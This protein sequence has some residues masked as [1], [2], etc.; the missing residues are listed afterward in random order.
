[1]AVIRTFFACISRMIVACVV[2]CLFINTSF[3]ACTS[4]Q[5][6]VNGNGTNCQTA[7]FTVTTTSTTTS[8]VFTMAAK[9]TFYV[10]C[11][12]N[13][14]LSQDTSSYGTISGKTVTRT[15]TNETT[16]TCTWGTAGA[17]TINFGG[18]ATA[19]N[20]SSATISFYKSSGGTQANVASIAG[21]LGLLFPAVGTRVPVFMQ[22]FHGT[23]ITSIPSGLFSSIDTSS[24]TSTLFMFSG[25]FY[26][27]SI[28]SIPSGLFSSIDTSS[29]TSTS[30]MFD[31]TFYNC[32]N[33]T[34]IPSGLFS[35]IDTSSATSTS[36]MFFMTFYYTKITSIPDGLF[37]GIDTSSATDT[38]WMFGSTFYG[39]RITSIPTGLFSGIDTSSSTKTNSMFNSTFFNTK[40]TSIPAGLFSG[41]DTSSATDTSYM[42]ES[43]FYN[44]Q[45]TSIPAG[46]FSGIDTSSSTNTNRMFYRTFYNT[47]ITSIPAGLFSTINTSSATNTNQMFAST[48]Y[49][50]S[51]LTGYIPPTAFPSTIVP[52]SS[53]S[54]DMWNQT[55]YN[56][57][58]ATACPTGTTQYTT[59]FES[60]W[61][62]SNGNTDTNGTNRVSCEPCSGSLP[63]NASW[64]A[65]T[66][67][68]ACDGGY[69]SANGTSCT[70]VE[71][72]Y[73]S[74]AGSNTRSA[75]TNGLANSTYTGSGG[76]TNS[77]PW[78]CNSGYTESNGTCMYNC[79]VGTYRP[80]LDPQVIPTNSSSN[81]SNMT[82]N[83]TASYGTL[84]G[85]A[86]CNDTSGSSANGVDF[87]TGT[88][89][90]NCW[91][92]MTEPATSAWINSLTFYFA[93]E[94]CAQSCANDCRHRISDYGE[95]REDMFSTVTCQSC[96]NKPSN[97]TY[98][99]SGGATDSCPW[100]CDS[101]YI[102]TGTACETAKF[103]VTTTSDTTSLSWTMTATGTFYVDCGDNGTLS[104]DTSSYGTISGTTITRT[105]TGETTYTCAWALAGAHTVRFG[106]LATAEYSGS[107]VGAA[108]SFYKSSGGT[109]ENVAAID[110]SLGAMF[111]FGAYTRIPKFYRTFSG[112]QITS[113][114]A[115]LFFN[116]MDTSPARF[117]THMFSRTFENCTSLQSIPDGLFNGV[118][119]SSATNTSSMFNHTFYNT[120]IT[121]IPAG[122]FSE[123]D[124]SSATNTQEMFSYTFY[125]T[126]ITSIPA[127]LFS[128]IDTSSAT[129]TNSM[130]FYTFGNT[131][132]TSIPAGLFSKIDT[133]AATN[134]SSMFF[135]T[136]YNTPITS[137]PTGL[138]SAINTSSATNTSSMFHRT[139]Y[140][141]TSLTGYIPPT[142]FPNTIVP[143]SSSSGS[144]WYQTF[145]NTQLAT[146]C[147]AG[148]GEYNTG[149]QNDWG[150]SNGNTT[151][152]GTHRVSCE[153]C[154]TLPA[155]ATWIT[156]T[157]NWTCDGGYYSADGTSC[158]AVE[159]GYYSPAGDNT[160]TACTSGP[161]NSSYTGSGGATNSCPW[162]CDGGYYSANGTSCTAVETGYYSPA[163][164]N[165]RSACTNGL[166]NSTYTGSGGATDSC[167]Y[168]C[169]NGY[170]EQSAPDL[171]ATIG[172][173]AGTNSSWNAA[174][175][176]WSA[177]YSAGTVTGKMQCSS[178]SGTNNNSN[179]TNPTISAS[180][181]DSTGQYCY[182]QIDGWTPSGGS[183]Q[184]LSSP[185]VFLEDRSNAE[186][187]SDTGGGGCA[188]RC[189]F[190]MR[191]TGASYT[192]Y[193]SAL[194]G[195][196]PAGSACAACTG[197]PAHASW[198]GNGANC[199]WVCDGGYY[200]SGNTC[201]DA[202]A[203]YYSPA[204]DN[205][206]YSCTNTKPANSSYSGSASSNACPYA[207]DGGYYMSSN[208]CVDVDTG[209]YSPAGDNTRTA[210][211]NGP[212]NS[213][214]TGSA[215]SNS[216]PWECNAGAYLNDNTCTLCAAGTY[217]AAA[218]NATTCTAAD[219]GYYVNAT[220]QTA[221]T[222]CPAG[223]RTGSDGGRDEITDCYV[224]QTA[225]CT[226]NEC[227][228]P[229]TTGCADV[230]CAESC[231]CT[232]ATYKQHVNS[233][234]DGNGSTDGTTAEN[235]TKAVA[236]LTAK[237]NYYVNGTT[238]CPACSNKPENSTY[239]AAGTNSSCPWACDGGYYSANGTSCTAVETGYYSPADDNERHACTNAPVNSTYTGSG[240]ATDSCPWA[241]DGGY[242]S[243]NG[244]S[245]TAVETGYYSPAG[246]N[247]R[248]ACTNTKPEHSSYTDS[249]G[250]TNSCPWECDSGYD[251]QDN[252]CR[253]TECTGA[254]YYDATNNICVACPIGYDANTDSGKTSA[255]QCQKTCAAGTYMRS[256][257]VVGYTRL[258]YIQT[259]GSQWINTGISSNGI[260]M[261]T[262][263]QLELTTNQTS[264]QAAIGRTVGGGYEV[265]FA[266]GGGKIGT[267][268]VSGQ[269]ADINM[270][271]GPGV[272]YTIQSEMTSSSIYTNINGATASYS[273]S[274]DTWS[275]SDGQM[276]LFRHAGNYNLSAKV[277]YVKMWQNG[278]LV[279]NYV[280]ARRDS[281]N[282]V[283]MYDLVNGTFYASN[284]SAAFISGNPVSLI[285]D[286]CE[287]VGV[288]YAAPASTINYG[289]YGTRIT[290]A[291]GTYSDVE[292]GASCK[293]CIGATYSDTT[294]ASS[295]Q[296]CPATYDY[297]TESGK[298]SI[299]QCQTHCNAGTYLDVA[300]IN[301][302][303]K[304]SYIESTGSQYIN[305][306]ISSNGMGIKA[307]V[308]FELTTNSTA[309]Q[310]IV[311]RSTGGGYELYFG[312]GT[313]IGLYR[314][315][316]YRADLSMSYGPGVMYNIVGEITSSTISINVN[317]STKT[318]SGVNSM[319]AAQMVL[320][321]HNSKYNISAKL[322]YAKLWNNG[323]LVRDYIPVKRN[324][325]NVAGLYDLVSETFFASA[326]GSN[327]VAGSDLPGQ[328][329]SVGIGYWAAASN[330]NYGSLG[331][332]NECT[333]KPANS[334]YTAP[335]TSSSC[336]F[337]CDAEYEL[338]NGLCTSG[339]TG[340]TYAGVCHE[341]CSAFPAMHIANTTYPLF[342]DR[343][344]ITNPTM[345][346]M[347]DNGTVC[348]MFFEPDTPE[349]HSGFKVL[350]N[351]S[352]YHAISP[353]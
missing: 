129:N 110:G 184:S 193:R 183:A 13:G 132:I 218:G 259:N 134:T 133:S 211:T 151:T 224:T 237:L 191:Y 164:S 27:T 283:G 140:D 34:S 76:A 121:S 23:S 314:D 171:N 281:D 223:Y 55:F 267:Y 253:I 137:I 52:G 320:F 103:S 163:G 312:G 40:I 159:T 285:G 169:N 292:N 74:P 49:N 242:Y 240:G 186:T 302:Y 303:T 24:A 343:T 217:K 66:C 88:T 119:T 295:C 228:N 344:S 297:N 17:H 190:Y 260:G 251:L 337:A 194:L 212:A 38:S 28:T 20:A 81:A 31:G 199:D 148:T 254:T 162:A 178:Q 284:G 60:D 111:P 341:T 201:V 84:S 330:I 62:Y 205:E 136:F 247:T 156:G 187:C 126:P 347:D 166:A 79:S 238:S 308:Q 192:K 50:C 173:G 311:G 9:G 352:V 180:L 174:A 282:V 272:V 329:E 82:W 290:C 68:W 305:T 102:N 63:A 101:G 170:H 275:V 115:G 273:G 207:C 227:S 72:G 294:A 208:L 232:G 154:G 25:T 332:R 244:T 276:V 118:D 248:T 176:T 3:A 172:T 338:H 245:C 57:Q 196:I 234:G 182:C 44:A 339:C 2:A 319:S 279:R 161:A 168:T 146:S 167:P 4:D 144:M 263:I 220:G 222:Q 33:I 181:P 226:Q 15:S 56:T 346:V 179:W 202:G 246:D 165:T 210:C 177:T 157:C 21:D 131:A 147:P 216:C 299:S 333:N 350:Y 252:I 188:Y 236:S 73:Y 46:L 58:L 300:Q 257:P 41:I 120:P 317:G 109:Q 158:T 323:T 94:D 12:D 78:T 221:Q 142:A 83:V 61:G 325:D 54:T 155:N 258:D 1:M 104:Q 315:S 135:Y 51:T 241:C 235:C 215:S 225:T 328:C 322:Y 313:T 45:I 318:S 296:P 89:G 287:N 6:D 67:T 331:T 239:T 231:F 149:F 98:T 280:P 117:T 11:G 113:I 265:Y 91:C 345:N 277:Y 29:A 152:D 65:G 301:G 86:V 351:G 53:S 143:G 293:T 32:T 229:D 22:T 97:S 123:I 278:T 92:K 326:S 309:E 139:F 106:G 85:I 90:L 271:Y 80:N 108:I 122:L 35:S 125:N 189:M 105:G 87:P 116:G 203:G 130:F 266:S 334:S 219:D 316:G 195:S 150:Y 69:Y 209:Y 42:F 335:G 214:Y 128:A 230:T 197:L 8:L 112:T 327:F 160:R 75:C 77:C 16:Y 321:R 200:K 349:N 5:I 26:G 70:A 342:A 264:E 10:D 336:P 47:K 127:G 93:T 288:G 298:T 307:D 274:M 286:D 243:A 206:R 353:Q 340:V 291:P 30:S 100:A 141:C 306:G 304:L 262:D 348:Y 36:S 233:T 250:A 37:S 204:G 324:S 43:A 14:T 269:R 124:T 48:F 145:Y 64:V 7:K 114:P 255:S 268:R 185:W 107:E 153:P 198:S 96:T 249:G 138:F 175:M 99:G 39:T 213:S 19:Y 95:W 59:G 270:S 18:T 289:S 310:A 256:A 71:T 261:K